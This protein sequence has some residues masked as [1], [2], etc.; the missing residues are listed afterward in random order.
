MFVVGAVSAF[1]TIKVSDPRFEQ[2]GLRHVTVKSRALR[3]RADLSLFVPEAGEG[4]KGLPLV[5][6]LHGV[7]S[8][9]WG[10]AACAGAHLTTARLIA[11]GDI[12]P[13]VLAMPSDGLWGDGSGYFP[14]DGKDFESWIVEEVPLAAE[15]AGAP[16]TESS[17]RFLAGLSM[18]GFGTLCLGARFGKKFR[19]I[20]AH[21][22]ITKL[23]QLENFVEESILSSDHSSENRSALEML[24]TH[25]NNLPPI[26][27][28]CG[29]GDDLLRANRE[30][31]AELEK[32]GVE[33]LY[34]EFPGGHE[35]S[36]WEEHLVDTLRFFARHLP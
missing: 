22:S 26:R 34:E 23:E 36:Y 27:F 32:R 5:T 17:P 2:A 24:L 31:H 9:H 8:S 21:S 7:Y 14:H 15:E 35:W 30:L 1:Y 11:A 29:I 3:Q 12:P 19:A 18:G 6:L 33:H 13:L 4:G 16:V 25:R 28:D 20:S 10:W